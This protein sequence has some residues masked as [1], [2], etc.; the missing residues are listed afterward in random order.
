MEICVF[1]QGGQ[2]FF[3]TVTSVSKGENSTLWEWCLCGMLRRG[4]SARTGWDRGGMVC[5]LITHSVLHRCTDVISAAR[6]VGL[7]GTGCGVPCRQAAF[8]R[9]WVSTVPVLCSET[10]PGK[11]RDLHVAVSVLSSGL[12]PLPGCTR[13]QGAGQGHRGSER[14]SSLS[15]SANCSVL[16]V[17]KI[18]CVG[19]TLASNII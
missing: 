6:T 4:S 17:L 3:S 1:S 12:L 14:N 8:E 18:K 11:A 16:E 15:L 2:Y 9:A 19:V 10:A 13:P 7:R 5:P